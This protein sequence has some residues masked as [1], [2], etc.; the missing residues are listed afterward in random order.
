[1]SGRVFEFGDSSNE[2]DDKK[3][4]VSTEAVVTYTTYDSDTSDPDEKSPIFVLDNPG[5]VFEHHISGHFLDFARRTSFSSDSPVAQSDIRIM[6]SRFTEFIRWLGEGRI[7]VRLSGIQTDEGFAVY[8]IREVESGISSKLSAQDGF[9]QYMI[10]RLLASRVTGSDNRACAEDEED[11]ADDDSMKLT[12]LQ[13]IKDFLMCAGRTFPANIRNWARRN[14][15]VASSDEVSQEERR[16]AQRALSIMMN[17]QW[18]LSDFPPIDPVQARKILDEELYGMERVKQRIIETIIQI[19]R[20]HR[21]PAYGLLL[22]GPAG[23]GKSQIAYAVARILKL[24]WATLDMSSVHDPEQLTGSSRIYA[25]AKPGSIMEAF[26][27]AG[28][29]DLVFIINELDKAD[30]ASGAG[31]P[32]DALLT[33]LDNLGYTDN[34]MECMIPTTGV[35]PIATAN[36]KARISDPLL[37]RF[38]VIELPDYTDE[39]K[40]KIF[41][42]FSLPKVLKRLEL[43]PEECRVTDDGAGE[44]VKHYRNVSGVRDLEQAAEHLA[45]HALYLI[46]TKGLANVCYDAGAVRELLTSGR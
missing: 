26:S 35:Y 7:S 11:M 13:S 30:S 6:D 41:L 8:R 16:H 18:K 3:P 19:N 23:T 34:Y 24:P 39:E 14:L 12:S 37:T 42:N 22:I 21:L 27:R 4:L 36:E 10:G 33:L 40:K 15:A 5:G 20:T 44:V 45:A 43:S 32:A 2:A 25:N 29:S 46:E 1:M 31:N 38:A 9:L 28:Q 17:I